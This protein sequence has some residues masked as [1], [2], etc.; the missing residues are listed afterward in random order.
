MSLVLWVHSICR[1][2][3][4]I[5][6]THGLNRKYKQWKKEKLNN[7]YEYINFTYDWYSHW[8]SLKPLCHNY[9]H[10]KALSHCHRSLSVNPLYPWFLR[11]H[12]S[13]SMMLQ[14]RVALVKTA[15]F[16]F[17]KQGGGISRWPEATN[18]ARNPKHSS[19]L[20]TQALLLRTRPSL[21]Q[22]ALHTFVFLYSWR[23]KWQDQDNSYKILHLQVSLP[24]DNK[25]QFSAR[26]SGSRI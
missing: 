15:R 25:F 14:I 6:K 16:G 3:K 10:I 18:L 13:G 17:M 19:T 9:F 8:E 23:G 11:E 26:N 4:K 20:P 22:V 2:G 12:D 21:A 24:S 7:E 5:S 1:V